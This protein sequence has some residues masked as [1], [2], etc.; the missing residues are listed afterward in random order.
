MIHI[1]LD[2]PTFSPKEHLGGGDPQE[3][4]HEAKLMPHGYN[5]SL[6]SR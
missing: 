6:L 1:R 4:T 5:N 2:P 3:Y